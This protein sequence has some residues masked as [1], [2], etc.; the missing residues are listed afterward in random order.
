MFHMGFLQ[1][2]SHTER[3]SKLSIAWWEGVFWGIL[4][5]WQNVQGVFPASHPKAFRDGL[6][7]PVALGKEEQV[8]TNYSAIF[9]YDI[10]SWKF[11]LTGSSKLWICEH[12]QMICFWRTCYMSDNMQ[13]IGNPVVY[14][15]F[16]LLK[17]PETFSVPAALAPIDITDRPSWK[18]NSLFLWSLNIHWSNLSIFLSY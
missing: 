13:Q 16:G 7:L 11:V 12:F 4:M 2:S 17:C 15:A 3:S 1:I 8:W 9:M 18:Q 6:Q 10:Q 5:T 14:E